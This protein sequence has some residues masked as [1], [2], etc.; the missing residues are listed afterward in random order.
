[1]GNVK[2]Y[3]RHSRK[4]RIKTSVRRKLNS[5]IFEKEHLIAVNPTNVPSMEV[6][7][8]VHV[9]EPGKG[10]VEGRFVKGR[11]FASRDEAEVILVVNGR[12][13]TKKVRRKNSR[14]DK[15]VLY[16]SKKPAVGKNRQASLP[17][18]GDASSKRRPPTLKKGDRLFEPTNDT[19]DATQRE[20][21]D[22]AHYERAMRR[23]AEPVLRKRRRI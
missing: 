2:R 6:F 3:S 12:R 4:S 5:T 16:T 13:V 7:D 22:P 11:Y 14:G 23:L 20:D 21:Y 8:Y 9:Q 17:R 15:A 1:M 19:Y 10:P 18:V